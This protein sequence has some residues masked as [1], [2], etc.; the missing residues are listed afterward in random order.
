ML[1]YDCTLPQSLHGCSTW[2]RE[3]RASAPSDIPVILV[4]N[5]ADRSNR[6]V[7]QEEGLA[8]A[9]EHKLAFAETSALDGSGVGTAFTALLTQAHRV[10]RAKEAKV[11]GGGEGGKAGGARKAGTV[12]P[13]EDKDPTAGCC[14]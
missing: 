13:Q 10:R 3:L 8:F 5:K 14:G 4:G 1:V 9:D 12:T 2:L 11:A 7:P 6:R